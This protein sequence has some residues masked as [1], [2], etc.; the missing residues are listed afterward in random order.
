MTGAA[1]WAIS[2]G[3][4]AKGQASRKKGGGPGKSGRQGFITRLEERFERRRETGDL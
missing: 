2:G 1:L 4:S 3:R